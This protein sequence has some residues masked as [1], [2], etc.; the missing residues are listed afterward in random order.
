[1]RKREIE[2]ETDREKKRE[3]GTLSDRERYVGR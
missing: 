2:S 3:K 1:M